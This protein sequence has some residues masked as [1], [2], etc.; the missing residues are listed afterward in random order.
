[1]ASPLFFTQITTRILMILKASANML[2]IPEVNSFSTTSTSPTNRDTTAPGSCAGYDSARQG[3]GRQMSVFVHQA[4]AQGMGNFLSKYCQ[5]SFPE[6]FR[7]TGQGC[8]PKI[9]KDQDKSWLL[10]CRYHIDHLTKDT[11]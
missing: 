9:R 10:T 5:K 4:A 1:M 11:P 7:K 8:Q 3:I 6:A 2:M